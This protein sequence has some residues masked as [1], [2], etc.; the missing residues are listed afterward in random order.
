MGKSGGC[1]K[2]SHMKLIYSFFLFIIIGLSNA[3]AIDYRVHVLCE[4]EA[5]GAEVFIKGKFKGA[6]PMDVWVPRE[7]LQLLVRKSVDAQHEKVFEHE[8]Y[9]EAT[10]TNKVMVV[11]SDSR[12]ITKE[13]QLLQSF[14]ERVELPVDT[15]H[16]VFR[17]CDDCPEM[18][19]I[20]SGSIEIAANAG[21]EDVASVRRAVID[22]DFAMGR[23]EITQAQWKLIMGDNPSLFK[24]CGA[25]C[26]VDKV[27]R[28]DIQVFIQKLNAI[29]GKQY[30]LP[31]EIEWEYAAMAGSS[32]SFPWG[33]REAHE[34]A[35]LGRHECCGGG[36]IEGH[37][38]WLYTSPVARFPANAF[39][40]YDMIGNVWEWTEDKYYGRDALDEAG[41]GSRHVL[42]GGG[43][44][45]TSQ[46]NPLIERKSAEP[47][48]YTCTLGFRLV[49]DLP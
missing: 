24:S 28:N 37:D 39:G 14:V 20:P 43:W 15:V 49:R 11:L 34:Y 7:R 45:A 29:S 12:K 36:L 47:T 48:Y 8:L 27:S 22:K 35:N 4:G 13:H 44:S 31:S 25:D 33:G 41:D 5:V 38:Q 3:H 42:R 26:P 1:A 17:D 2:E 19:V 32:S 30:R 10:S 40:L 9:T 46:V 23:T 6:C 21:T 16:E 18:V